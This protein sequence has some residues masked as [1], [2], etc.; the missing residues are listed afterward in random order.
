MKSRRDPSPESVP[1]QAYKTVCDARPD[2]DFVDCLVSLRVISNSHHRIEPNP[3]LKS[4][5]VVGMNEAALGTFE[6][7]LSKRVGDAAELK[8]R[9]VIEGRSIKC[10]DAVPTTLD[11]HGLA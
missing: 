4:Q 8:S 5:R 7:V 11:G 2:V 10:N 9:S 1:P 6:M 3:S